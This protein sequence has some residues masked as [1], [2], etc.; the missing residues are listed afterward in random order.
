MENCNWILFHHPGHFLIYDRSS[1]YCIVGAIYEELGVHEDVIEDNP[2]VAVISSFAFNQD[3]TQ[4]PDLNEIDAF[5]WLS[6][7]CK[8]EKKSE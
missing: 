7:L 1:K 5:R 3:K 6:E 8:D 4:C 2:L